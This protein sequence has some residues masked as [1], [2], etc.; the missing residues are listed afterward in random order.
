[1]VDRYKANRMAF[2]AH[3]DQ[4]DKAGVTYYLHLL[5]VA[6]RASETAPDELKDKA[7]TVGI[8]HDIVEDTEVSL[9]Q[10]HAEFGIEIAEAVR[11]MTHVDN[12]PW[13]DYILRV[14]C[15]E[16]AM[17]VKLADLREN[18]N[19]DRLMELY[20][21]DLAGSTRVYK[22]L[23]PRYVRATLFLEDCLRG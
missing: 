16:L 10:I 12:E 8:L 23:I 13:D 1:M 18:G 9:E 22:V 21:A 17:Y 5:K 14:S 3:G 11:A 2:A 6:N 4:V 7:W 19:F 15:N 20:K